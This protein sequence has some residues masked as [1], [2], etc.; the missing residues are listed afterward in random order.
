[1]ENVSRRK[2]WIHLLIAILLVSGAHLSWAQASASSTPFDIVIA[3]GHIIDG[4]GSPWYTA[5]L[6]IRDGRIAA[7]CG[8]KSL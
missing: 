1:M 4:T 3:N 2:L 5:D 6:G 7:I 8:K